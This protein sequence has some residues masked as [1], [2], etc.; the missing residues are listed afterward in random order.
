[1][2][3]LSNGYKF[4]FMTA[5]AMG[6]NGE[7]W[8]HE[9]PLRLLGLLDVHLFTHEMKSITW[10]KREGNFRWWKPGDCIKLIWENGKIVGVANAY[11]LSNP[12]FG[13]WVKN[14]GPKIDQSKIL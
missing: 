4:E 7:G 11:G 12:G 9:Q 3:T 8:P 1:M 6:Y 5:S 14:I 10:L 13:W 2:I